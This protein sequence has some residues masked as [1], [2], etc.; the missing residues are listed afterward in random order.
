MSGFAQPIHIND[1]II[2]R[3]QKIIDEILQ[4]FA[5]Y[6]KRKQT[7]LTLLKIIEKK[8]KK[9]KIRYSKQFYVHLI[10][11]IDHL[12]TN[13]SHLLTNNDYYW[14]LR[15]EQ[16][17]LVT[18]SQSGLVFTLFFYQINLCCENTFFNL[19]KQYLLKENFDSKVSLQMI[20]L[21][22][23]QKQKHSLS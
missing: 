20:S 8:V 16:F 23:N 17:Y 5:S 10:P 13:L 1:F 15:N 3:E 22:D 21:L 11:L 7:Q 6:P 18:R 14:Y 2:P 9:Q 12:L 19:I 4:K